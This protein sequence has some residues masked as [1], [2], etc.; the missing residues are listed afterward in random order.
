M[1]DLGWFPVVRAQ[2]MPRVAYGQGRRAPGTW[3][4]SCLGE[5]SVH[6][7]FKGTVSR[8]AFLVW[9]L[10]QVISCETPTSSSSPLRGLILP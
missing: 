2:W 4:Y 6:V 3:V 7:Y 9:I 1:W 8:R 5:F 10:A